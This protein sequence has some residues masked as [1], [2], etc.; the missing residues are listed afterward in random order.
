MAE[1]RRTSLQQNLQTRWYLGNG[2]YVRDNIKTGQVLDFNFSNN[3]LSQERID[4]LKTILFG[5][6]KQETMS[7]MVSRVTQEVRKEARVIPT[8]CYN[9]DKDGHTDK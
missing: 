8:S 3:E 5:N 2:K 9:D 1:I 7:E 6:K 4:Q